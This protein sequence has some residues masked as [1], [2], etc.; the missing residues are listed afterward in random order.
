MP[1]P[2]Q[3]N[4]RITLEQGIEYTTRFRKAAP[5]AIKASLFWSIGGLTELMAQKDCAGLRIYNGLDEAGIA[6]HVLVAVDREGN[7]MT[8]GTILELA[9]PCPPFCGE[10]SQLQTG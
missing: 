2:P 3:R 5:D 10:I 1:T 6:V 4:H 9:W 8:A 7:D